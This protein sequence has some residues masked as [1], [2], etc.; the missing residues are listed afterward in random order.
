MR[1]RLGRA[2]VATLVGAAT[3]YA[4]ARHRRP[5]TRPIWADA[6]EAH[7]PHLV[8][9]ISLDGDTDD[10]GWKGVSLRTG[11]FVAADGVTPVHPHSEARVLWGD[12][13]LYLNLYAADEDIHATGQADALGPDDDFFHL[14]FTDATTERILDLN[15]F[16]V[17][18]DGRRPRDGVGAPDLSWSSHAH[19]S[20][21]LD[22]TPNH[23]GDNDEEWVLEVAIPFESLGLEGEPGERIGLAMDRCDT[24]RSGKRVCGAW[25]QRPHKILVL[26]P[27]GAIP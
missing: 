12:G 26:D 24:L 13:F 17:V 14:V 27:V 6:A 18:R 22:G 2:I 16:G 4:L 8:G 15:P 19:V 7:V 10:P 20:H 25:G 21:E 1:P 5:G 3:A 23:P 11:A 9:S